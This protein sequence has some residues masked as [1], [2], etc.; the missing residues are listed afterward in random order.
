MHGRNVC[1]ATFFSWKAIR[2][3]NIYTPP[4]M[5]YVPKA[6]LVKL[7]LVILMFGV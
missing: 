1:L 4:L 6:L 7:L 3:L 2:E 5:L